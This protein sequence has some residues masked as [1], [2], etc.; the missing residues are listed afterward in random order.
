MPPFCFHFSGFV[1]KKNQLRDLELH[2]SNREKNIFKGF[3]SRNADVLV[4]SLEESNYENN[5]KG[6]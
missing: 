5:F 1:E 3:L 2:S 4:L 6:L